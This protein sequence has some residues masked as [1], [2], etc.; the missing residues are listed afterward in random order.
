MF[1]CDS[2]LNLQHTS[3]FHVAEMVRFLTFHSKFNF[4][5]P[6]ISFKSG[7]TPKPPP[8]MEVSS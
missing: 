5:I 7:W 6:Q 8:S 2:V 4:C 3:S 1:H